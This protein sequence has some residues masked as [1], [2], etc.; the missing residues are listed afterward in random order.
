MHVVGFVRQLSWKERLHIEDSAAGFD[1][2]GVHGA[3]ATQLADV[4]V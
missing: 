4:D 1:R 2:N 3:G